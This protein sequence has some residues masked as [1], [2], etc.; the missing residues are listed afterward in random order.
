[1]YKGNSILTV[2][3]ARGGSRGIPRKNVKLLNGRPLIGYTIEQAKKF[4]LA[5]RIV[6]STDDKEIKRIAENYGVEV[7]FLRPARLATDRMS[8]VPVVIHATREAEK[9]WKEKYQIV[10]SLSPTGPLRAVDDIRRAVKILVDTKNTNAVFSVTETD[11]NPYFNIYEIND[12]GYAVLSKKTGKAILRRQEAP[13][14][15]L[16]NGS[17]YVVRKKILFEES[18]PFE[19]RTRIYTMPK[20]RSV[21]IDASWDFEWAEFLIKKIRK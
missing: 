5:D 15:F 2:I 1:M 3:C 12:E 18:D 11:S 16:Q 20:E 8:V 9:Y 13:R 17:I 10:V 7:P 6:V 14:A 21:D 4:S 19:K